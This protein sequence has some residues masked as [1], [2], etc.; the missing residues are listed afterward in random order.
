MAKI[1]SRD[2]EI[3]FEELLHD[4][5]AQ[6]HRGASHKSGCEPAAQ[7]SRKTAAMSQFEGGASAG[8]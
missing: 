4:Q 5:A 6:T 1:G 8:D 3:F 7:E 2:R